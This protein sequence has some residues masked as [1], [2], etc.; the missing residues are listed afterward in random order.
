MQFSSASFLLLSLA[1]FG[2]VSCD[3]AKVQ[4]DVNDVQ[5]SVNQLN[6]TLATAS[7]S[8]YFQDLSIHNEAQ[9]LNS[10]LQAATTDVQA[11]TEP[12]TESQAD[13]LI[14]QLTVV[15]KTTK[16]LTD[17]LIAIKPGFQKAGVTSL[18][19]SDTSAL[20][21]STKSFG[22]SLVDKA[23]DSRKSQAQD[24]ADKFNADLASAVAAYQ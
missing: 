17:R 18:V 6:T 20:A 19:K 21:D 12:V 14:N 1:L 22:A 2:L 9:D 8:D 16:Q 24:L 7:G 10:K 23:P 15:E 11:T 3:F 13:Q 5:T 4:S